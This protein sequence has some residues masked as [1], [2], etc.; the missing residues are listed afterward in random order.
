MKLP[1]CQKFNL[2]LRML[3][4]DER[5]VRHRSGG[6]GLPEYFLC[7]GAAHFMLPVGAGRHQSLKMF[8]LGYNFLTFGNLQ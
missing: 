6:R 3:A 1:W 5:Q 7:G 4:G 2:R 8:P